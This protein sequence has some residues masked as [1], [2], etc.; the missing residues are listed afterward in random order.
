MQK[1]KLILPI[2]ILL[3]MALVIPMVSAIPVFQ[4]PVAGSNWSTARDT[5]WNFTIT[6]G[7]SN[8]IT[9]ISCK[10]NASGGSAAL[11]TFIVEILNTS[12]NQTTFSSTAVTLPTTDSTD[13]NITCVVKNLSCVNH[14]LYV[15]DVGV[16]N[17]KPVVTMST[18]YTSVNLG[19][20]FKYT[21]SI[22]DATTGLEISYCNITDAEGEVDKDGVISTSAS[23]VDFTYTEV[24]GTYNITCVAVDN[25]G[26]ANNNSV[27]V[28][29]K[30]T[31]SPIVFEEE[32]EGVLE[33]FSIQQIVI[34]ILVVIGLVLLIGRKK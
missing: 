2:A 30:A 29:A 20:Y 12:S 7:I 21:I 16:D 25:A 17:T 22:S 11:G 14:T 5:N 27:Q 9:N 15:T 13:Y 3:V 8:E 32:G 26:N 33:R 18:D 24:A 19:R 31:G 4:E 1:Q 23:S 10:Y 6:E 28:T 34:G